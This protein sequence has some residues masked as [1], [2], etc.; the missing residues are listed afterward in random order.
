MQRGFFS[1]ILAVVAIM[2]GVSAAMHADNP[3]VRVL[4]ISFVSALALVVIVWLLAWCLPSMFGEWR[5]LAV[6]D[7]SCPNC[8]YEVRPSET[9]CPE[10]D[11]RLSMFV[12]RGEV[13]AA[14]ET[15][16]AGPEGV[17]ATVAAGN[18]PAEAAAGAS[19]G[20]TAVPSR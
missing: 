11:H 3:T 14:G 9:R 16:G 12:R 6:P 18:T 2:L 1:I 5:K 20:A 10:C 7:G 8:G 4:L 19:A 15:E 13:P 17:E